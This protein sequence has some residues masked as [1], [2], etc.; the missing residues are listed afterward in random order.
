[1]VVGE[2]VE[3]SRRTNLVL[4]VYKTALHTDGAD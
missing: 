4:A 1:M 2:R 3:R